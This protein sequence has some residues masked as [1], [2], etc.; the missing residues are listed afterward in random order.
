M[1]IGRE[2]GDASVPEQQVGLRDAGKRRV[3]DHQLPD[4][5][6]VRQHRAGDHALRQVLGKEP[7]ARAEHRFL[8]AGGE[9]HGEP[10]SPRMPQAHFPVVADAGRHAHVRTK[11]DVVFDIGVGGVVRERCGR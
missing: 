11:P 3:G 5:V 1:Q 10:W 8:T 6:P 2:T 9:H 4:A 7:G